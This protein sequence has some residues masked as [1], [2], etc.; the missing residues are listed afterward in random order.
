MK[1]LLLGLIVLAALG[2]A[3]AAQS[4]RQAAGAQRSHVMVNRCIKVTQAMHPPCNADNPCDYIV[5][6]IK[7]GCAELAEAGSTVRP[8]SFCQRY[9]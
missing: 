8:P 4:C 6:E 5:G 7:H 9:R 1:P 3:A 2:S